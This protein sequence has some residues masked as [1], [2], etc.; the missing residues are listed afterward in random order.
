[1]STNPD[2][3]NPDNSF[4]YDEELPTDRAQTWTLL[5]TYSKIPPDQIETH[6]KDIVSPH[7]TS[8]HEENPPANW[9]QRQKAWNVFPYGCIGHWLFLDCVIT[10]LPEYPAII[11]RVKAGDVLLDAGCAF[12]YVLR[13]MAVDGAPATNLIGVDIRE[14][15]L[16]LGF[17][18][19]QDKG[20]EGRF[21][22]AD[23]VNVDPSLA[24][25]AGTVDIIHAAALFH[26]FGWDDQVSIGVRFVQLFKPGANALVIG[27]QIADLEP[28]DPVEHAT[29]GRGWYRHNMR[30]WQMLW[31]VVGERTGTRWKATG[32]VSEKRGLK[33]VPGPKAGMSFAVY[34]T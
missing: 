30:T 15:F 27:R 24:E 33:N 2:F 12:G 19:F 7:L 17:E 9:Y 23:L 26:L 8:Q 34:K 28:L 3:T 22:T 11:A 1:M 13:Q 29:Q 32:I 6:L 20:F 5:E 4:D 21:I 14:E 18:L 16:D 10:S 25:I 31:D